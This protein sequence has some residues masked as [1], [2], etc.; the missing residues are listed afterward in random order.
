M[1]NKML[2][3]AAITYSVRHPPLKSTKEYPQKAETP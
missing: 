1:T 2:M 3:F